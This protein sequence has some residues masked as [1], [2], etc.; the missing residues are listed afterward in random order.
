[1]A[2]VEG[3]S[4][5]YFCP[6]GGRVVHVASVGEFVEEDVVAEGFGELHEGDVERN[7]AGGGARA[8][9]GA[10]VGEAMTDVFVAVFA[11]KEFE[12]VGEVIFGAFCEEFFGGVSGTLS[13]GVA[14]GELFFDL[15]SALFEKTFD[16]E[17]GSVIG[18]GKTEASRRGD[19]KTNTG[20]EAVFAD[21]NFAEFFI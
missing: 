20:G 16:E 9:A 6:E 3:V 2:F 12:A 13:S 21:D 14:K 10:G 7:G 19:G 5:G 18:Y 15:F 1:M 17:V 8:P 11:C 4:S